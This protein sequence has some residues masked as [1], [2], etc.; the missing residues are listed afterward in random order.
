[1][2]SLPKPG[3]F[4]AW[5]LASRP[6]TLSA[7][8]APVLVGTG[9]AAFDSALALVPALAAAFGAIMLQIG[10]NFANDLF[11]FKKGTDDES[12]VGPTRAAQAG[13]LS[14]R[15]LAIGTGV[16]FLL[17]TFAGLYLAWVAGYPIFIVG[18][19]SILC[20]IAYTGGPFPLGYHGLGDIFVFI[21]FGPVAVC[22]TAWVQ[23][24]Y[25]PGSAVSWS[26]AL[27]VLAANILVVNNVR[28]RHTD[29]RTGKR[30]LPVRFGKGAGVVQYVLSL[31]LAFGACAFE[32]RHSLW[33]LLPLLT[34]PLAIKLTTALQRLEGPP[35]NPVLGKT[36]MLLGLYSLLAAIGLFV[37]AIR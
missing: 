1:M 7:A 31:L 11:D 5:L 35:L 4:H 16:S 18:A 33:L 36:A 23:L 13:L 20:A 27:G 32:A 37:A 9:V 12:R 22:G 19:L 14:P 21:F 29:V 34:L 28:D 8:I 3:S 6:K 17:A 30:T 2:S 26:I 10:A 24:G 25:I 15:A